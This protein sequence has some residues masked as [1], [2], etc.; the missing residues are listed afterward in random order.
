MG[1]NGKIKEKEKGRSRMKKI[2]SMLL[3]MVLCLG[4]LAGCGEKMSEEEKKY[5]EECKTF[6]YNELMDLDNAYL[7]KV[8]VSGKVTGHEKDGDGKAVLCIKT[9]EGKKIEIYF[10]EAEQFKNGTKVNIWGNMDGQWF[11]NVNGEMISYP[12]MKA[13]Y[14]N[15]VK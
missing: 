12:V 7:K 1:K 11:D 13:R 14:I 3:A 5:K 9:D 2:M 15:K 8:L 10:E 6:S 4:M